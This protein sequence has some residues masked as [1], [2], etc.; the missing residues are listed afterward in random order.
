MTHDGPWYSSS[1]KNSEKCCLQLPFSM[2]LLS[3]SKRSLFCT[4]SLVFQVLSLFLCKSIVNESPG[5]IYQ[6]HMNQPS[7]QNHGLHNGITDF[8]RSTCMF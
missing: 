1:A 5:Q 6:N 8:I 3:L 4:L 2:S 7:H